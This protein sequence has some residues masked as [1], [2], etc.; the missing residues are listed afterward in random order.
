MSD[1]AFAV[2][3]RFGEVYGYLCSA[4]WCLQRAK[5]VAGPDLLGANN[6]EN[7]RAAEQY[8]IHAMDQAVRAEREGI[9]LNPRS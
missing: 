5:N 8:A 9:R 4:V 1:T 3:S 6:M 2:G 7:I